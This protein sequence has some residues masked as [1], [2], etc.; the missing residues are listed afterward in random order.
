MAGSTLTVRTLALATV[1][2]V[3]A[4]GHAVKAMGAQRTAADQAVMRAA[5]SVAPIRVVPAGS[6]HSTVATFSNS[7]GRGGGSSSSSRVATF[8]SKAG[9]S[10]GSIVTFGG[11][12]VERRATTASAA[13]RPQVTP[14]TKT[15]GGILQPRGEPPVIAVRRGTP[16]PATA[17]TSLPPLIGPPAPEPRLVVAP[18]AA[19]KSQLRNAFAGISA[20]KATIDAAGTAPLVYAHASK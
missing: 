12:R 5:P 3:L 15:K 20:P 1:A 14:R 18:K 11:D 9:G 4:C 16:A 19:P 8:T 10:S 13:R 7:A 17:P 2:L 6:G